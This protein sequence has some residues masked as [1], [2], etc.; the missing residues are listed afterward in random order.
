MRCNKPFLVTIVSLVLTACGGGE[1]DER[2]YGQWAEP[3]T[4]NITDIRPNGTL[5]WFGEE[6]TF[7]FSTPPAWDLCANPSGCP[8]GLLMV[9][10]GSKSF[11]VGYETRTLGESTKRWTLLYTYLSNESAGSHNGKNLD[12]ANLYPANTVD[13]AF[14]ING[15]ERIDGGLTHLYPE[16]IMLSEHRGEILGLANPNGNSRFEK[17]SKSSET[18]SPLAEQSESLFEIG[19]DVI[20]TGRTKELY[21]EFDE[22][23]YSLDG[24]ET[25]QMRPALET[26]PAVKDGI[27]GDI[28][29]LGTKLVAINQW[30]A[31]SE[32]AVNNQPGFQ[33]WTIELDS[34][35]PT[36]TMQHEEFYPAQIGQSYVIYS[37]EEA[38]ALALTTWTS[39]GETLR[40]STNEGQSWTNIGYPCSDNRLTAHTNGIYCRAGDNTAAWYD[41]TTGNWT[42]IDVPYDAWVKS[43]GQDGVVVVRGNQVIKAKPDGSESV[44]ATLR[45]SPQ[46]VG[47]VIV[48]RDQMLVKNLTIW[49]KQL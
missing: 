40:I 3:L 46:G 31:A 36:W 38:G 25:F 7:E 1:M 28:T 43:V 30:T 13:G 22:V 44:M 16:M 34:G 6:G 33:V 2:M 21:Y 35:N 26:V 15:F 39:D 29:A 14:S 11:E 27:Q 48:S 9:T 12:H 8:D 5:S 17:F 4:G 49:R 24:G 41:L 20:F 10:L 37:I 45:S 23:R 19:R 47:E 18:W 42:N 32:L